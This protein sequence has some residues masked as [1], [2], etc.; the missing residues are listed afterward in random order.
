M[1]QGLGFWGCPDHCSPLALEGWPVAAGWLGG[2]GGR[3]VGEVGGAG[4]GVGLALGAGW[5]TPH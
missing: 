5:E 1:V 4:P 3:R 2:G